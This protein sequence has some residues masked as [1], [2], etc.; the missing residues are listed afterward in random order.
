M[1]VSGQLLLFSFLVLWLLGS[2]WSDGVWAKTPTE[3]SGDLLSLALPAAAATWSWSHHGKKGLFS[4]GKAYSSVILVTE[5]LKVTTHKSRPNG[6]CCLAFPS[7]HT[8]S[9]FAGA[10]A[11]YKLKGWKWG[12]PAYLL[13]A[14]VGYTRVHAHKHDRTDVA[15]GAVVGLGI[16]WYFDY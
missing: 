2:G 13:A 12:L 10:T 14:Y 15:G 5:L 8:A 1:R 16:T 6:A 7:G 3:T 11:I 9:A 4:F